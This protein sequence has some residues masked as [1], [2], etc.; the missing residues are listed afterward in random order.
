MAQVADEDS[1]VV[2]V[3]QVIQSPDLMRHLTGQE[4]TVLGAGGKVKNGQQATFYTDGVMFGDSIVVNAV[5]IVEA[6]AK[7]VAAAAA[8]EAAAPDPPSN[9]KAQ[10]A[11]ER[12]DAADLVVSGQ[13]KTVHTVD[14]PATATASP[15][16]PPTRISEHE[17]VWQ[18]AVIQVDEVHKGELPNGEVVIRFPS[19]SDVLWHRAP[20]FEAGQSGV[21]M[22]HRNEPKAVSKGIAAAAVA[23]AGAAEPYTALDPADFHPA[24]ATNI[25]NAVLEKKGQG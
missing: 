11:E 18:D 25:I 5:N 24:D 7:P 15:N 4:V 21:F 6:K 10:R 13:V 3:D 19:S 20:K 8:T 12:F 16:Q 14:Q 22:L 2:R 1:T 17:P 23:V 9:L